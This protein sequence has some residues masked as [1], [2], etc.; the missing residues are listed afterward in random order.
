MRLPLPQS[1]EH[2]KQFR[3]HD[4]KVADLKEKIRLVREAKGDVK[5]VERDLKKL[6]ESAP[7]RPVTMGVR[8]ANYVGDCE[9]R[10]RG[11]T[12]NRGAKVPRNFLTAAMAGSTPHLAARQSGRRELSAWLASPA[13]PLTARVMVNRIWQ[14]LFGAG[15]VPTVDNFGSTGELPSH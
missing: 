1:P 2:E 9:I 15:I 6:T 10:I 5:Q 8:D 13:N 7:P 4:S 12:H 14:H 3:Y 11:N